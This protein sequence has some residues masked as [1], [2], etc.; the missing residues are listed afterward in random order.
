MITRNV[1]L[2]GVLFFGGVGFSQGLDVGDIPQPPIEV[3]EPSP[4]YK[5]TW[6]CS[7]GDQVIYYRISFKEFRG[8][9]PCKV[10]EKYPD[11]RT[12]RIGYSSQT[13]GICE[14]ALNRILKRCR[15]LGMVCEQVDML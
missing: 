12:R 8:D 2:T 4:G 13:R 1:I 3:I 9:P 10:Y 11:K 5:E 14:A 15:G 6:K 7:K